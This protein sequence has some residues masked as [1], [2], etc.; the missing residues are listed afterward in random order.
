MYKLSEKCLYVSKSTYKELRTDSL[1]TNKL[2]GETIKYS[3]RIFQNL[4]TRCSSVS[5]LTHNISCRNCT[6]LWNARMI[7]WS[8]VNGKGHIWKILQPI[9]RLSP[10]EYSGLLTYLLTYLTME[11]SPSWEANRFSAS[12]EIPR[13]LWN[14]KFHYR[15]HK[16]PP[17]FPILSQLDPVHTPTSHF[18]KIHLNIILPSTPGSPMWPLSL[19]YPHHN[20]VYASLLP[21]YAL[22]APPISFFSILSPERII[23]IYYLNL[24]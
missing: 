16:C 1:Y 9:L 11:L 2:E 20:P 19:R 17:S 3:W 18:L 23:W 7:T 14:L 13:I 21:P 10:T 24:N 22:Q 4:I 12:Q 6:G 5:Y 15:I 8:T